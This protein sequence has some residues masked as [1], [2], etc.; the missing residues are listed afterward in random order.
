MWQTAG[1]TGKLC[2]GRIRIPF[3]DNVNIAELIALLLPQKLEIF[4]GWWW[5]EEVFFSPA[6]ITKI[7]KLDMRKGHMQEILTWICHNTFCTVQKVYQILNLIIT[8]VTTKRFLSSQR[9]WYLKRCQKWWGVNWLGCHR[10]AYHHQPSQRFNSI[11]E[12][13][14]SSLLNTVN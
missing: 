3:C 6:F 10:K 7:S 2:S 4:G 14:N 8:Y 13:W 9:A 12:V 11:W 5:Q 1:N